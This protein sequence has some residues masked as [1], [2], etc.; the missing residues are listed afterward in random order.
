[1]TTRYAGAPALC[2]LLVAATTISG[3]AMTHDRSRLVK[4]SSCTDFSF[5][6][7]FAEDSARVSRAAQGLIAESAQQLQGCP[8]AAVEI[9]GLADYQGPAAANL[10]L[11]RQ[12]GEAAARALARAGFPA[13]RFRVLAAGEDGSIT[14]RGDAEPLR[15]RAEVLV[16]F[17]R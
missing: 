3:C 7:Y 12:R 9:V 17:K 1:M 4:D 11:S 14:A 8:P 10:A 6:I 16:T 15:R 13:P 5:Q 2:A